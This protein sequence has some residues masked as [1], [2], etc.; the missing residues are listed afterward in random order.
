MLLTPKDAGLFFKVHRSLMFFVNQRLEVI[1]DPP[2]NPDEF[3]S[4]PPETRVK[5]RD[6]FLSHMD[7]IRSFVDENPA[8]LSREELDIVLSCRDLI[9]GR[10]FVFRELTKYTVF[11][12]TGKAPVAY[13]VLALSQPF[14]ELIGPYLPVM[15]ETVLLPFRDQIV[16]DGLISRF[17][18]S[19]GSGIRR[20]LNED[21]KEAKA[22]QGI[23]TSLPLSDTPMPVKPPK[24][25]PVSK[26]PSKERTAEILR[27]IIGMI[28]PF[29]RENLNDEYS[30]L[31]GKLAEK[32]A[33]KRPSPLI[34]GTAAAWA[35]GIVR[36][37]GW[38][39][40][41]DDK[42]QKPYMK[43]T[44]VDKAFGVSSG[45]GQGKSKAIR[46]M[47]KI[48]SFDPDWTLPSKIADNPMVWLI[49]LN[50]GMI[51]DARSMPREIQEEAFERGFIPYV[52]GEQAV[53][54]ED[55]SET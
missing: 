30:V 46:D 44:D 35:C 9:H 54:D 49:Q 27:A 43:M 40:F 31:C 15:V 6:A 38:V 45:T 36:T 20:G 16:Y 42:T 53:K 33:R 11:L 23:V 48:G 14:E 25:K 28:D 21:F 47:L 13:G 52:P 34:N 37:I 19:F 24:A 32:L 5:V 8:H 50:G 39:N 4:L 10:F 1:P 22:R 29:C 7:L 51:V 3:S 2:A 55:E 41:L 17:N 26:P 18:I 12:S